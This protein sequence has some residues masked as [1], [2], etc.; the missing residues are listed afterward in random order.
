MRSWQ[1]RPCRVQQRLL[2]RSWQ[3]CPCRVQQRLLVRSRPR[4]RIPQTLQLA[5]PTSSCLLWRKL[6]TAS[7]VVRIG[8]RRGNGALAGILGSPGSR[9]ETLG[10]VARRRVEHGLARGPACT[11]TK[12]RLMRSP[13]SVDGRRSWR[14]DSI[15]DGQGPA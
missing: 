14:Q 3:R 12:S 6:P 15:Q 4:R 1:L 10:G 13:C 8:G 5:S 7:P 2:V 11:G 9:G